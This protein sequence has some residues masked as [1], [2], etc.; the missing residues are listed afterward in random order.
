VDEVNVDE[1]VKEASVALEDEDRFREFIK[2]K[3]SMAIERFLVS[4]LQLRSRFKSSHALTILLVYLR[5]WSH[6][7][8][9]IIC[10]KCQFRLINANWAM[11]GR[12]LVEALMA[13]T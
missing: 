8:F 13:G 7:Y 12:L 3:V 11:G 1:L 6:T 2:E 9:R 10:L 5:T 4:E